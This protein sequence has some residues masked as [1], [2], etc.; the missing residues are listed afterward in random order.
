LSDGFIIVFLIN[1][2]MIAKVK[3]NTS[4]HATT[5]VMKPVIDDILA[6]GENI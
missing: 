5:L 2:S 1:V 3:L 4:S 6:A